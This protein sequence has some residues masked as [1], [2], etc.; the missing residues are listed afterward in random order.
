MNAQGDVIEVEEVRRIREVLRQ[1]S[2]GTAR[3]QLHPRRKIL[4][5]DRLAMKDRM[6]H[7]TTG[8]TTDMTSLVILPHVRL[9]HR[10]LTFQAE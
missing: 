8:I 5:A 4:C 6:A 7:R 1:A 2:L 10:C 3:Q 9:F